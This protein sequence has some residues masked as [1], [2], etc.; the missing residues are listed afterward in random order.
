M[1]KKK[2][3]ERLSLIIRYVFAIGAIFFALFP[4]YWMIGISFKP[5]DE[6]ITRQVIWFPQNPTIANYLPLFFTAEQLGLFV[7]TAVSQ[8]AIKAIRNSLIA[9]LGGTALALFIGTT[10]AYAMSRYKAG[11]NFMPY[12]FLMFRM[13]PPMAIIVPLVVWYTTLRLID[14]IFGLIFLYG[15]FP[16]PFVVWLMR[17]F[18]DEIPKEIDEAALIDGCTPAETFIRVILPLVKA[19]LAV[20]ALFVFILNWSDL[21]VALT[22]TRK[23]SITIPVQ[24]GSYMAETGQLYGV[25]AALG[26]IAAIPT[27]VFGLAIQRYLVR[28]FTFGAIKG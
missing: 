8:T 20:T 17:S 14:N 19:G 16:M 2:A 1:V 28:G 15:L 3:G 24:L 23:E 7:W 22:M 5:P 18:F 21:L 27:I 13:L 9:G 10:A 6:W 4:V 25:M 26:V 12:L 11:G